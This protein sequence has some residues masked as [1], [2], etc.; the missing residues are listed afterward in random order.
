M[1]N[2]IILNNMVNN[3]MVNDM[4]LNNK[5]LNNKNKSEGESENEGDGE[6]KGE[7]ENKNKSESE[8][9][10]EGENKNEGDGESKNKNKSENKNKNKNENGFSLIELSI[11]LIIMGL[12]IAGVA[13]GSSMIKSAKTMKMTTEFKS[14]EVGI[15]AYS[16]RKD[17]LPGDLNRNGKIEFIN[18]SEGHES[19]EAWLTLIKDGYISIQTI[20]IKK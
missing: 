5:M 1:L 19:T 3:N 15:R 8:S 14:I 9:E 18:D 17:I 16:L 13:G 4:M 20:D 11:V 2:S 10:S 7:S 12:L 6:S